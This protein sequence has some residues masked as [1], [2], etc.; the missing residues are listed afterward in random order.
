VIVETTISAGTDVYSSDRQKVGSVAYVVVDPHSFHITDIIVST[1]S[2]LGRDVVVPVDQIDREDEDGVYL[3]IDKD[4]L[5][6]CP[7]YVDVNYETPPSTWLPAPG[8]TYPAG[9]LLWPAGVEYPEEASV[10]V[11]TP[12]GTVGLHAGMDVVSSD[13]HKVGSIDAMITDEQSGDVIGFVVKHGFLFPNDTTIPVS[14][15]ASVE[16]DQVKLSLSRDDAE[17]ELKAQS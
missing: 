9:T 13:G 5:K 8:L 16:N 14:Q 7:D 15:V 17:R 6:A 12:K 11:N 3:K 10:T 4:G 1:G 2:F